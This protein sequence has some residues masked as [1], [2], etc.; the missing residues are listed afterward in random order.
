MAISIQFLSGPHGSLLA[1]IVSL[2]SNAVVVAWIT[3]LVVSFQVLA[4]RRFKDRTPAQRGAVV[5]VILVGGFVIG[6]LAIYAFAW[7]FAKY[8]F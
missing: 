4:G 5:A 8:G 7:I 2:L 1:S 6:I 3:P